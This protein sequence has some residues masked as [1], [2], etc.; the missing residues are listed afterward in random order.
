[1]VAVGDLTVLERELY[2]VTEAAKLL[3]TPTRKVHPTTLRRWLEGTTRKGIEYPPVLRPEPTGSDS[4]MWAEFVEAGLLAQFRKSV[5]L[6]RL[7]PLIEALR[8]EFDVP[9]P[10]AHFKPMI[11]PRSKEVILNLQQQVETPE[12]LWLVLQSRAAQG[13]VEGYQSLIWSPPVVAHLETVELDERG[14]TA[15]M[16]PLGKNS[17]VVI[18]PS[19]SFGIP[20][21]GGIRTE[22]IAELVWAGEPVTE[23]ATDFNLTVNE[24]GEAL[25]WESRAAAA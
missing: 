13:R 12:E 2:S 17:P 22:A 11:D 18:D 3:T 4:V 24:I 7:R 8:E 20:T 19:R 9:Y 1:M 23:V 16:H 25:R 5:S 6:Q 14:S 21:I 10:L 15:R